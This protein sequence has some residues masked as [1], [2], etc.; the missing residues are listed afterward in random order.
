MGLVALA[1][2]ATAPAPGVTGPAELDYAAMAA[3]L[4]IRGSRGSN[5]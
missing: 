5:Q 3:A 1:D 4:R 2:L